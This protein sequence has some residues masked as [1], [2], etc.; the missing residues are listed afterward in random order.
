MNSEITKAIEHEISE[1]VQQALNGALDFETLEG[2]VRETSLRTAAA[3]LER[4]INSAGDDSSAAITRADDGTVLTYV[5]K[6]T[7]T[8]VTVLGEITLHRAYYTDGNGRGYFPQDRN[9]GFDTD[10]LSGGVKRMIGHTA[11][12]LSFT[13]SSLMIRN[14]AGLHVGSKHVE[15]AGEALGQEIINTEKS[16]VV[17]VPPCSTTMYLGMDG[18]GCPMR[19]EE[20]E[21]RTG[22]QPDGSAKTREVKLAV[23]FSADSRD[24]HGKP[25]RDVGSVSYNAAIE[26]AATA[27]VDESLS[28]FAQRTER[29][30]QRRGFDK[31]ALQVV[32]GDGAKWI[33]NIADEQFPDA[34][35][36]IDL[37][38][39]KGTISTA[40]KAIFGTENK[41]G[42]QWA[43][44]CRDELEAGK[45]ERIIEKLKAFAENCKE[46]RQCREYLITNRRRLNYPR[47]RALGLCTSSGIV[48][49][50]CKHV[51]GARVKQ[52]GMHWTVRGANAI[53]ALRC[54]KLSGR[55]DAFMDQRRSA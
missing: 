55:F 22:K 52:S 1:L 37:F 9:L 6:R 13:E 50:G 19:K 41:F 46:A 12:V 34:I 35:Q 2:L 38:H 14:L 23:V 48:E 33:W 31:A 27:D 8:F 21:G 17:Q 24:S 10:C 4:M 39:A 30:T 28:E 36:I 45:L 3:V 11:G 40:A 53:I 47:F 44:T 26:S 18:T 32:I 42:A 54:F 20:T 43:K 5:G 16:Q 49:S 51:I 29:E 7:K 25:T 15:R